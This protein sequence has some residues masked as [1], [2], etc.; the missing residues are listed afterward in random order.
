[1]PQQAPLR[2]VSPGRHHPESGA[3]EESKGSVVKVQLSTT[4]STSSSSGSANSANNKPR[5]R[6]T[7][8]LHERFVE[9]VNKLDGPE[10]THSRVLSF[11]FLWVCQVKIKV[12][13]Y[14]T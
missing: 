4:R 7:L 10:S 14:L 6:W 12:T 8:E 2:E 9:A 3:I 5:L 1:V 11:Y 13:L